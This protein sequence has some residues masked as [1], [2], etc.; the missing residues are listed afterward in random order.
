MKKITYSCDLCKEEKD[1]EEVMAYKLVGTCPNHPDSSKKII[2]LNST[3]EAIE[4]YNKHICFHCADLIAEH[5]E[6]IKTTSTRPV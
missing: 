2:E 6:N 5:R 4:K 3:E 1:I